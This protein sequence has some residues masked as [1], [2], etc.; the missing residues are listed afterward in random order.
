M[1]LLA[2]VCSMHIAINTVIVG[3]FTWQVK[4]RFLVFVPRFVPGRYKT[5]PRP[6]VYI[7]IHFMFFSLAVVR[8][9][10]SAQMAI[11]TFIVGIVT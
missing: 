7:T 2:V 8:H 5:L 1:F 10:R 11:H 9:A 3:L 6:R 4:N